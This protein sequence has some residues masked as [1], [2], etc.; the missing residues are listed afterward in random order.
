MINFQV[1]ETKHDNSDFKAFMAENEA[2]ISHIFPHFSE[3][4]AQFGDILVLT[5]ADSIIGVV[6]SQTK[7]DELH[8]D[9]DYLIKKYRDQGIG[10]A[11][12]EKRLQDYQKKGINSVIAL[13]DNTV[14]INYLKEAG[15]TQSSLY[16]DRYELVW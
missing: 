15:F 11:F 4:D 9:V 14:H 16:P 5:H 1:K 12:F 7:G 2:D 3:E 8:I 10:K 6:I 13:T